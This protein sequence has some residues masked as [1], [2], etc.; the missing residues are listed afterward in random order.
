MSEIKKEQLT[1]SATPQ[2]E[3]KKNVVEIPSSNNNDTNSQNDNTNDSK[4]SEK[5]PEEKL[6]EMTV[7]VTK[8]QKQI[9]DANSEAA[10]YKRQLREKQSVDE[11][12]LQEKA[13]RAAAEREEHE[14][15]KKELEHIKL[16]QSYMACGY[17]KELAD[18]AATS[19]I[20]NDKDE[21]FRIQSTFLAQYKNDLKAEWQKTIPQANVGSDAEQDLF[22]K[23]F[24][25][26]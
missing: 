7:F 18:K 6:A 21:L 8:L 16:S 17:S 23:G 4:V 14:R 26:K 20:E 25:G 3:E 10:K 19:F 9:Q 13:E 11:I 12:A 22:L 24:W 2:T 1:A 15:V 5:T